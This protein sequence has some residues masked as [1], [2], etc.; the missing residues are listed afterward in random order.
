MNTT[1]LM[2]GCRR[3]THHH[4]PIISYNKDIWYSYS[5]IGIYDISFKTSMKMIEWNKIQS[6]MLKDGIIIT[7]FK[8]NT[9]F[10]SYDVVVT[11]DLLYSALSFNSIIFSPQPNTPSRFTPTLQF[12][13]SETLWIYL[14]VSEI[15]L[16]KMRTCSHNP[17]L[18][19]LRLDII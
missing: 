19:I 7:D 12:T 2:K 9:P 14:H 3:C 10:D 11:Q 5:L 1:L 18:V 4:G 17:I 8:I 13:H 16:V 15:K 6:A